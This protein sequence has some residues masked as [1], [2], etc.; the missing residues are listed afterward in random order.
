MQLSEKALEK[1]EGKGLTIL[2][3]DER[4]LSRCRFLQA[5]ESS[6]PIATVHHATQL[7]VASSWLI[8]NMAHAV[9]L[10]EKL[11]EHSGAQMAH[12]LRRLQP[13][14]AIFIRSES[15]LE[16]RNPIPSLTPTSASLRGATAVSALSRRERQVFERVV[17]GNSSADIGKELSLSSKTVDTYR[18]R[19]MQKLNVSDLPGL[20]RLAIRVGI[21]PLEEVEQ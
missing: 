13:D 8:A 20:V 4:P 16:P 19:L 14:V 10:A 1:S 3:V 15:D 11:G 6:S 17:Q 9:I 2:V 7:D 5:L 21:M 12:R 18:S